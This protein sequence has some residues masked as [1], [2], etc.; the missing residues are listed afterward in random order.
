MDFTT[1][2]SR[3]RAD[4]EAL[5]R[6]QRASSVFSFESHGEPPDRYSL[7]FRGRGIA[8]RA[9]GRG[10]VEFVELHQVEL[11]LPVD[12]PAVPPD[13]RWITPIL[14]PNVSF[15]GFIQVRDLGL[16][17]E[18]SVTLD[19]VCERLW[20]VARLAHIQWDRTTNSSARIWLE[21]QSSVSLPVD[22]RPL[23][24]LALP[25]RG[26][27]ASRPVVA[28]HGDWTVKSR[29]KTCCISA[30]ILRFRRYP[31][32]AHPTVTGVRTV[33]RTSCTSGMT[34]GVRRSGMRPVAHLVRHRVRRDQRDRC[35]DSVR[36]A[37]RGCTSC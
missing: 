20:D 4:C 29:T 36:T 27:R 31:P 3:L 13:L 6:L 19:V 37:Q 5:T 2:D 35:A 30:R 32:I 28:G 1:R 8:R 14:H 33:T 22:A 17:W 9:A 12:Y 34:S 24:D 11:R 15:S 10:V 7:D 23:R 18:D 26:K 21:E 25:H 16:P